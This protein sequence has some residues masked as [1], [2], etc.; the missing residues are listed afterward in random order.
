MK[1]S[2][3]LAI[4]ALTMATLG[5]QSLTA[6]AA[7]KNGCIIRPLGGK[8]F[9][10]YSSDCVPNITLPDCNIPGGNAPETEL[11]ETNIPDSN[12]PDNNIPDNT[13]ENDSTQETLPEDSTTG[14]H[15]FLKEVLNLVNAER[16]REGL[17]ALTMDTKVQAAAQVRAKECKQSFSHTRPNGSSF[18]TALK[19]QNVSYRRAGENIAWGQKT[20]QAVMNAW[21]NSSGH[22]ANIM[23]PDYTTMGVGYY[24]DANGIPYWCQLFTNF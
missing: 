3:L 4:T 17:S 18:A 12:V 19:E 14:E 16:A 5:S 13:P 15:A 7:S 20:P 10:I 2:T 11:P 23:N 6:H 8:V 21:M 24:V 22:R 1:K 9:F